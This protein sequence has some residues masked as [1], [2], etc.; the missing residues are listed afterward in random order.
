MLYEVITMQMYYGKRIDADERVH[1][2]SEPHARFIVK[3]L[4]DRVLGR[5]LFL[6]TNRD[7][8]VATAKLTEKNNNDCAMLK[9]IVDAHVEQYGAP[10]RLA[11]DRGFIS[12][13]NISYLKDIN[14]KTIGLALKGSF[15]REHLDITNNNYRFM[16]KF[17]AGVEANISHLK[18]SFGLRKCNWKG[19]RNF[20]SGV[21]S[22][23]AVYNILKLSK[24]LLI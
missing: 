16:Q 15:K 10:Y 24:L 8:L 1:S 7:G 9:Q 3:G 5:K 13:P 12:H 22:A 18:R 21:L 17:R 11:G 4:R 2:Y 23:I 14:V 20:E 6:I 19:A